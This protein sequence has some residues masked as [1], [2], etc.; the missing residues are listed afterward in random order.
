[1]Y[2]VYLLKSLYSSHFTVDLNNYLHFPLLKDSKGL[3]IIIEI[4]NLNLLFYNYSAIIKSMKS[5]YNIKDWLD[6]T[7]HQKLGEI[8]M[9]CGKLNLSDLGTALD[10]QKFD[11][12]QLGDILIRMNVI[13]KEELDTA[14]KLQKQIDELINSGRP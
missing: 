7:E 14:L 13:S 12:I 11:K 5:L 6:I 1:M 3:F 8:L 10:I 4:Y 9:Q 2:L